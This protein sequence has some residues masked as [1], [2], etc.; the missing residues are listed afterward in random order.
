MYWVRRND[1]QGKSYYSFVQWDPKQRRNIR[2]RR[3][4]V[5]AN[6]ATDAQADAFCK[7]REAETEA[8]KFRIERKLSWQ[9]TFYNF[10]DLLEIFEIELKRRAP[11]SWRGPLYYFRQ[12]ALD[13]FLNEKQSNN[14]NNWPL[15]FEEF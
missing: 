11:N 15:Y 10:E 1:R 9:K 8:A 13:F 14:I 6:V 2:L 3:S 5:P 7:V 4:E 12:Y